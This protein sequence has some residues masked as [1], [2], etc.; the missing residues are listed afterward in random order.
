MFD[1]FL[2]PLIVG[3]GPR[4]FLLRH[5]LDFHI[6]GH[7]VFDSFLIPLI[8][9]TWPK[10]LLFQTYLRLSHS[11][12][13]FVIALFVGHDL[14]SFLFRHGLHSHIRG[15]GT[16]VSFLIPLIVGHVLGSFLLRHVLDCHVH[17]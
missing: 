5:V 12:D 6:R 16:F 15:H 3:H 1:S 2:I 7:E 10:V 8:C 17:G 13:T 4:S 9:W 11:F 14:G